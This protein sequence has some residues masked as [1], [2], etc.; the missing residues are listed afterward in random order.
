[1]ATDDHT[2]SIICDNIQLLLDYCVR[3]YDRQFSE[4]HELNRDVL[5]RFENLLNEYF[6]SGDAERLGLPTVNYFADKISLSPNYFGDLVKRETGVSAKEYLRK[7]LLEAAKEQ[8]LN[9]QKSISQVA[10]SLG[11]Q[12]PQD[13]V[14]CFKSM[15]GTTPGEFRERLHRSTYN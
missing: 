4:R 3:F 9:P 8:L 12:Y 10:Q 7:K 6:I 1:M 2:H 11:F 13:F 14:R 5:Q 15:T